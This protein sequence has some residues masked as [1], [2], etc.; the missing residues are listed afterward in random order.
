MSRPLCY[1][2]Y[3]TSVD[4]VKSWI[5]DARGDTKSDS[6]LERFASEGAE[7]DPAPG[8]EEDTQEEI[9]QRKGI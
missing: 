3:S 6:E 2:D 8:E 7:A 4:S 1:D 9:R 5:R